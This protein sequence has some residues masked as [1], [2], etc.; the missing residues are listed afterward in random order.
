MSKTHST[1]RNFVKSAAASVATIATLKR[2]QITKGFTSPN[3]RPKIAAIGTGSRWYIRATG[4]DKGYG[5]APDMRK[6]GDYVAVCDVDS[7]RSEKAAEIVREWSGVTPTLAADYREIIDSPDVDIVHIS[8]P[9][10]WHAKIAIEAISGAE[11]YPLSIPVARIYQRLPVP[12]AAILGR[13][14]GL[15]KPVAIWLLFSVAMVAADA[16]TDL[17]NLRRVE[18]VFLLMRILL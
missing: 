9:D 1:R 11:P 14:L 16:A 15:V 2:S 3:S 6:Y 17:T 13:A 12:I 8:T 18:C 4:I 7:Q 5:S 10:H